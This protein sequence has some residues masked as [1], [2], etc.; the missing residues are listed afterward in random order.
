MCLHLFGSDLQLC[1]LTILASDRL[2]K[3]RPF[4]LSK[5]KANEISICVCVCVHAIS[6]SNQIT[7]FHKI[8]YEH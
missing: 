1:S 6:N 8:L 3:L 2:E 7:D 5:K 4:L